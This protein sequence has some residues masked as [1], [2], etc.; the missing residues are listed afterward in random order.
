VEL[1]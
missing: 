1:Q